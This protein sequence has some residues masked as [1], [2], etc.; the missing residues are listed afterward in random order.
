MSRG[1]LSSTLRQGFK[2]ERPECSFGSKATSS[3]LYSLVLI[4]VLMHDMCLTYAPAHATLGA[5]R[6]AQL[7]HD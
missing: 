2:V 3:S 7:V 4:D 5:A 1:R 6:A